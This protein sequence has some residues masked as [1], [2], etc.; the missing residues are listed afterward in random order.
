MI[1]NQA[2]RLFLNRLLLILSLALG[3]GTHLRRLIVFVLHN[4]LS[5]EDLLKNAR[6]IHGTAMFQLRALFFNGFSSFTECRG[7]ALC[8]ASTARWRRRTG[9][10]V[11]RPGGKRSASDVT[12][13]GSSHG[14]G[15]TRADVVADGRSDRAPLNFPSSRRRL[16]LRH[17]LRG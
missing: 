15:G 8:P 9:Q 5:F 2:R 10:L 17:V 13:L 6:I 14:V 11:H 3:S 12:G 4:Q 7:C 1:F 16:R